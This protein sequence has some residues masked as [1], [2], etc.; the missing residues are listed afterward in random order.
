MEEKSYHPRLKMLVGL[1]L[2]DGLHLSIMMVV[3]LSVVVVMGLLEVAVAV[4][5]EVAITNP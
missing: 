5:Q 3:D 4:L 1:L 2:V